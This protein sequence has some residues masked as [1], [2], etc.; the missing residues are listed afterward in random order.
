MPKRR[1]RQSSF[2]TIIPTSTTSKPRFSIRWYEG[3]AR[4]KRSG[5]KSKTDAAEALARVHIGLSDGTLIEK[6][7]AGVAF[8]KVAESWLNLHSKATLRSH[9]LNQLNY[10]AHVK[11]Y[12]KDTPLV[13]V[14]PDRILRFR[15]HLSN[16]RPA[17]P[18][19]TRKATPSESC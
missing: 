9:N 15:A 8:S 11:P 6:R 2:G 10:N 18:A 3:S 5:F 16:T 19:W 1:A 12:F 14:T 4:R 13:A 7:K 17:P